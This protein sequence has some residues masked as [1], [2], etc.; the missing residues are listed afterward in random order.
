MALVAWTT[1]PSSSGRELPLISVEGAPVTNAGGECG[2]EALRRWVAAGGV[3]CVIAEACAA[4]CLCLRTPE[5]SWVDHVYDLLV[6]MLVSGC[7]R[8]A[9]LQ[10]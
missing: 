1:W 2:W 5:A 4:P 8:V 6:D 9:P 3:V 10:A 7:Y